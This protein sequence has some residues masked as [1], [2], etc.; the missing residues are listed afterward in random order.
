MGRGSAY[1][2]TYNEEE[3]IQREGEKKETRGKDE[4]TEGEKHEEEDVVYVR[5]SARQEVRPR[6]CI[7]NNILTLQ[8][9]FYV[10]ETLPKP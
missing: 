5:T 10:K 1:I 2:I 6:N 9:S 7:E 8:K 3:K 4:E